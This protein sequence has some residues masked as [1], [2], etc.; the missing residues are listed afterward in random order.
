MENQQS[1]KM[2]FIWTV[3]LTAIGSQVLLCLTMTITVLV[4]NASFGPVL[5][6]CIGPAMIL[7]I[8]ISGLS[9]GLVFDT[10]MYRFVKQRRNASVQ[11]KV[12]MIAWGP[13]LVSHGPKDKMK[14]TNM[15]GHCQSPD[16]FDISPLCSLLLCQRWNWAVRSQRLCWSVQHDTNAPGFAA[17]H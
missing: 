10:L 15:F 11:H 2:K 3:T 1:F 12:A 6:T 14:V 17:H 4:F 13:P 8:S 9:N 7:F 16:H 5:N